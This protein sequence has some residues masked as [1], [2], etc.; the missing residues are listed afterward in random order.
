MF[1]GWDKG[2]SNW[3]GEAE[4]LGLW[5]GG[6]ALA[7]HAHGPGLF[8][9]TARKGEREMETGR[10][11]GSK[12]DSVRQHL[13][14]RSHFPASRAMMHEIQAW[15]E[16]GQFGSRWCWGEKWMTEKTAHRQVINKEGKRE[17]LRRWAGNSPEGNSPFSFTWHSA[18][19]ILPPP[20]VG[21]NSLHSHQKYL[22]NPL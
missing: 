11:E 16:Q 12:C 18:L 21:H 3:T 4:G 1:E 8:L 2:I 15:S 14:W 22:K 19:C 9:S 17:S 5:P 10:K 20:R 6:R 13:I 7:K